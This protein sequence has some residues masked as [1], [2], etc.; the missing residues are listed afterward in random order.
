MLC[1]CVLLIWRAQRR[2]AQGGDEKKFVDM[3]RHDALDI[4]SYG[5]ASFS[6]KLDIADQL[7][8]A[9]LGPRRALRDV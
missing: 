3:A 4:E 1:A 6:T 5:R 8:E 9:A 2:A 7:T